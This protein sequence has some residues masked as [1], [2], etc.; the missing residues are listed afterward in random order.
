MLVLARKRGEHVRIGDDIVITVTG[1]T[2]YV[3]RLGI[4]A[5]EHLRI[6]RPDLVEPGPESIEEYRQ[7]AERSLRIAARRVLRAY[8]SDPNAAAIVGLR[9]MDALNPSQETRP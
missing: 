3:A 9:I 1:L 6:S 2:E 5:P 8:S 4:D 7:R